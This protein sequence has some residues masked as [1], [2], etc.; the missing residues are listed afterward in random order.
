[1]DVETIVS[2]PM[3]TAILCIGFLFYLTYR[4]ASGTGPSSKD[5][6]YSNNGSTMMY[7]VWIS[8]ATLIMS[9]G[10]LFLS[11]VALSAFTFS[12]PEWFFLSFP[13]LFAAGGGV[14]AHAA[15][16]RAKDAGVSKGFAF[17]ALIPLVNLVLLFATP[18]A[19]PTRPAYRPKNRA[20]RIII[21]LFAIFLTGLIQVMLNRGVGDIE[22]EF[23][24]EEFVRDV[25]A[26]N[27]GLPKKLDEATI[28]QSMSADP[29]TKEMIVMFRIT[30][31]TLT[32]EILKSRVESSI[33]PKFI[34]SSCEDPAI[35][36]HGWK[37]VYRYQDTTGDLLVDSVVSREDC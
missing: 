13:L 3:L 18:A 23:V 32:S 6:I 35:T 12:P 10:S 7:A 22:S 33:R 8:G 31:P 25:E 29:I 26:Q 34:K 24:T 16:L 36:I 20:L 2:Q 15:M 1:M 28:L 5:P 9:A 27:A 37:A 30:D 4:I 14:L 17:I 21:G 11:T 19:S